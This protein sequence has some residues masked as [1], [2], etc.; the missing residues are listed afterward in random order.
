MIEFRILCV[1]LQLSRKLNRYE[2]I[3]SHRQIDL[4]WPDKSELT[5]NWLHI[6][7]IILYLKCAYSRVVVFHILHR[8]QRDTRLCPYL[9]MCSILYPSVLPATLLFPT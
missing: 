4:F 8:G 2:N 1:I 3:F 6:I 7:I 5:S 9:V